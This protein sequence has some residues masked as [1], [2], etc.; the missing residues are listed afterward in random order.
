MV[1]FDGVLAVGDIH[2]G[3]FYKLC[4]NKVKIRSHVHYFVY[5]DYDQK[6]GSAILIR[7]Y[8]ERR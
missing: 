2:I 5:A 6:E 3:S 8:F 7:K 4:L 1:S